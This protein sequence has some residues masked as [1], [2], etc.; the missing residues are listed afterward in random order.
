MS[1]PPSFS[2]TASLIADPARAVMLTTLLDGR[3]LPA[4]PADV[5]PTGSPAG[6]PSACSV[7]P[8]IASAT[9][10]QAQIGRAHV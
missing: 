1:F 7:T 8:P 6:G 3:A 10:T 9:R 4:D 5:A 2:V